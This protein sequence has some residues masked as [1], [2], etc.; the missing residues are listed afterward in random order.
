METIDV[1]TVCRVDREGDKV[2]IWTDDDVSLI[3]DSVAAR[4]IGEAL[5]VHAAKIDGG[6]VIKLI[7]QP[8]RA[9]AEGE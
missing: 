1:E 6:R 8:P 2:R 7:P 3:M 5:V 9:A 4:T